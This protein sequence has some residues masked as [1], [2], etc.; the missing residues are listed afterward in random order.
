M[1]HP[2]LSGKLSKSRGKLFELKEW[3]DGPLASNQ[4]EGWKRSLKSKRDMEARH[5][6]G[7]CAACI[8]GPLMAD[9]DA[10]DGGEEDLQR[11]RC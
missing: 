10:S 6:V 8:V 3:A 1:G 7:G 5:A 11:E 9:V 2:L 4:R